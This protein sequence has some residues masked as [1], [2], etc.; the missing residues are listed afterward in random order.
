MH[1]G[2]IAIALQWEDF[3]AWDKFFGT[4]PMHDVHF[5]MKFKVTSFCHGDGLGFT[6]NSM[7]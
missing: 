4:A 7:N 5:S 6:Q 1:V 3:R 2:L